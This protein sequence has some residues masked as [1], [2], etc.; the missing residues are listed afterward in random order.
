MNRHR[1]R[2]LAAILVV[3]SIAIVA[4]GDDADDGSGAGATVPPATSADSAAPAN[5]VPDWPAPDDPAART[6]AAGLAMEVK[7]HLSVHRHAHLDVF[8][9]GAVLKVPAAIGI[10]ITDPGVKHFADV[11][12]YGGITEC[13]NPCISPLHTHDDTGVLHTESAADT[14]LTLGQFF[15]EWGV[16]LD[17]ECVGEFCEPATDIA[18]YIDGEPYEGNPAD[19]ELEDRLAIV[20]VIGTPPAVIPDTADFSQA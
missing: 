9:D 10:D 6:T 11:G 12:A 15:T 16:Q 1:R 7:E 5:A 4:C 18:V 2:R 17:A 13:A 8:V 19:I 14:L 3:S 20:I